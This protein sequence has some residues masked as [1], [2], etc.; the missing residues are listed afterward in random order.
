MTICNVDAKSLE[1]VCAAYL[2][3]DKVLI[4]ELLNGDDIHGLNQ[5]AF[6]LPEGKAGRLIAKVLVFRILYGGTEYSFAQD[7]DFQ[8][9]SSSVKYWKEVIERFYEKYKGIKDWHTKIIQEATTTGKI[10]MCT[11]REY[12]YSLTPRGEWPITQIKNFPVQGLGADLMSIIRVAFY[13]RLK[14]SGLKALPVSSVHD[15]IV[16]DCPE[17]EVS[18]IVELYSEAFD[19]APKLFKQWFN[20]EFNL[21][22]RC[23]ISVGPNMD[24]LTEI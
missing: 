19:V 8:D 12:S 6:G 5:K 1:V 17:E 23:E 4:Q 7:A 2:S 21:P 24:Q 18:R 16:V 3:Q 10:V 9:V 22:L 14:A 15:S 11:G 20:V 13:K